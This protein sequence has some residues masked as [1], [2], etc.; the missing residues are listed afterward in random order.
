MVIVEVKSLLMDNLASRSKR[1]PYL[2][3]YSTL[4]AFPQ[5]P[6]EAFTIELEYE[7]ANS[8]FNPKEDFAILQHLLRILMMK[9]HLLLFLHRVIY[10]LHLYRYVQ[11]KMHPYLNISDLIKHKS[12]NNFI[13]RVNRYNFLY[14]R[15][16]MKKLNFC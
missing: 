11:K 2:P 10:A 5:D 7:N 1:E 4:R 3:L 13:M 16:Q 14:G 15:K 12:G 6:T 8:I 9:I